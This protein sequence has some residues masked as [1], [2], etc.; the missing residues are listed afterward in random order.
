[1]S[2]MIPQTSH[3]V[4][5]AFLGS[6]VPTEVLYEAECPIIYTIDTSLGQQLLAYVADET[7]DCQWV[8]LAPC[9]PSMVADLR[10]GRCAVRD[11]LTG[12]WLWLAKREYGGRW[13]EVWSVDPK[14]IPNDYLPRPGTVVA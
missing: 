6:G 14:L 10:D 2:L 13:L 11:A 1:M 3:Q 9:N 7:S 8:L 5:I 4:D 12:S